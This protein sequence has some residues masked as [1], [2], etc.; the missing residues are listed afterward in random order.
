MMADKWSHRCRSRVCL[1]FWRNDPWAGRSNTH[2]NWDLKKK[3]QERKGKRKWHA[4]R[5]ACGACRGWKPVFT[6]PNLHTNWH[7]LDQL[8]YELYLLKGK[9]HHALHT[10]HTRVT[11]GTRAPSWMTMYPNLSRHSKKA[12]VLC[13]AVQFQRDEEI[14]TLFAH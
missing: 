6:N 8:D 9:K 13:R 10:A 7:I 12:R 2:I 11:H 5:S 14:R 3:W 1:V 4:N